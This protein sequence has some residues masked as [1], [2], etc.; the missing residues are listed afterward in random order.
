GRVREGSLIDCSTVASPERFSGLSATSIIT[1]DLAEGLAPVA[2]FGLASDA[3]TAYASHDAM[4][5]ATQQW[6]QWNDPMLDVDLM[7]TTIHRFDTSDAG[8]LTFTGSGEVPGWLYSQ[9]ALSEDD[10]GRLRAASTT[11]PPWGARPGQTQSVVS[12]LEQ[13][14]DRLE[15]VGSVGGLGFDEQIYAVRF[16]GDLGYVVTFRQ[17]DPLYVIDLSDPRSPEVAGAVKIPGYSA[18]L[19]PVGD[20]LLVGV[21]QDA[22]LGGRVKGTQVALFDVSDPQDPIQ[23]DKITYPNAYSAVEWDHRAFLYW[24]PTST[25][26]IPMQGPTMSGAVALTATPEGIVEAAQ[27]T[28]RGYVLRNLVVGDRLLTLSDA[29]ITEV[30]LGTFQE[31]SVIDLG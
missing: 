15:V 12:V 9:W 5:V 30:R 20:G 8:A 13:R 3:Q 31:L 28:Q 29:A 24:A 6:H 4:Y 25:L 11:A 16:I 21:G 17:V 26:L 2:S 14:D 19:H 23:I 27:I 1:F 18:Y 22:D 10:E 7:T